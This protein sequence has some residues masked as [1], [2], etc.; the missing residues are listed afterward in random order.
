MRK[1]AVLD[2]FRPKSAKPNDKGFTATARALGITKSAVCQ[3][4]EELI[5]EGMAYRVQVVTRGKLK[6]NPKDYQSSGSG[7]K[8]A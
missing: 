8:A 4:D 3:W 5:P 2:H 1:Q 7:G 6:V